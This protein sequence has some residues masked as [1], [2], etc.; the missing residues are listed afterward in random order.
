[1]GR[2]RAEDRVRARLPA[3]G[4]LASLHLDTAITLPV[5]VE[6]YAAYALRAWLSRDQAVRDRTRRFAKRSAI[7]SFALGMAGQVAYH[8]LARAGAMRAPWPIT[9][10]V[11]CLPILVLAMGTALAHMLRADADTPAGAPGDRTGGPAR[12]QCPA[13]SANDHSGPVR[14]QRLDPGPQLVQDDPR[15]LLPL[16]HGQAQPSHHHRYSHWGFC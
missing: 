6:A 8:L 15:R 1:M 2:H 10:L 13:W 14:Q 9:T 5:G 4:H 12:S 11:S 7:F 16:P 3:A